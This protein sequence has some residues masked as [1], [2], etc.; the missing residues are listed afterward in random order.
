[1]AITTFHGYLDSGPLPTT[2]RLFRGLEMKRGIGELVLGQYYTY[3]N[4]IWINHPLRNPNCGGGDN[5]ENAKKSVFL[6]LHSNS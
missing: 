3:C 6:E 5:E 4:A 2:F 1:M